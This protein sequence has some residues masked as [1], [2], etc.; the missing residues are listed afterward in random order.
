MAAEDQGIMSLPQGG[1]EQ[2]PAPQISPDD[3]YDAVR[4]GLEDASPQAAT[5]IQ[6][7]LNNMMPMLDQVDDEQLDMLIQAFQYLL[8]NPEEYAENIKSWVDAGVLDPGMLPEEYDPEIISAI[9]MVLMEARRQRQAGNQRAGEGMAE[10]GMAE[11]PMPPMQM[12]RGGIAEA[13][14]MVASKGRGGD[15][16]LAHINPEEA[17]LLRSRGGAGTINPATGLPEYGWNPFKA[18]AKVVSGAVSGIGKAVSGIGRAVSGVVKSVVKTVKSVVKSPVGR[19]LATMALAAFIGPTALGASLGSAGT[20]ALSSGLVTAVGGGNVK[21]ILRSAATA[22]LGAPGGP[23]SEYVSGT[24][25][26]GAMNIT[27]AAAASAINAGIVGTGVGLLSGQKLADAVKSGL[28]SGAIS[29]GMTGLQ[30]GF[31]SQLPGP[32]STTPTPA[33][34]K[35]PELQMPG[36]QAPTGPG[37]APGT[38]TAGPLA[39]IPGG[40][41]AGY[42][43]I[44][45]DIAQAGLPGGTSPAYD[46][47]YGDI[48]QRGAAPGAPGAAPA[49][50]PGAP[51]PVPGVMDSL[52]RIGGGITDVLK[53]DFEK[54]FAG[55]KGGAGDLFLPGSATPAELRNSPEYQTAISKGAT[56][57]AALAEAGKTYNPSIVRSYG[58]GV[59][60]GLGI[61]AMSGGFT[62]KQVQPSALAQQLSSRDSYPS[63][64]QDPSKYYVQGLPGVKYDDRGMIIGS[65]PYAPQS[66]V[67]DVRV[68]TPGIMP[69][70][71]AYTPPAPAYTPPQYALGSPQGVMQPYNTSA[72]YSNLFQ[73]YS[74]PLYRNDGGIASLAG[75]GYPRR[76]GQISG[77]GTE[78]SDSIPA[79]LSDG[80]FVMTAKAVRGA[81]KGDRRAG[82]KK[83]YALMHQLERNASRG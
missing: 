54:G 2:P 49:G 53:G 61:M 30:R 18:V 60:A 71:P 19:I 32:Q 65:T 6:G 11:M 50:V 35:A 69:P 79:M 78:K 37:Q 48:A 9:L 64:E 27:N 62:P 20:A 80:E 29:G 22:Y 3:A 24:I 38:T 59:A 1:A 21:D 68:A 55:L 63:I 58:P 45:G 52:G 74:A 31:G 41:S 66:T 23:V 16:V 83:M 7:L 15:T 56:D 76:T 25:G 47:I 10:E 17:R 13:A 75:G 44:Y 26:A 81:G 67:A 70:A 77:P 28:V 4:G 57:A 34:S 36:A 12:A 43:Q 39:A 42:D 33:T 40:P 46:Q 14:R 8:D 73:P 51:R 5:D 72:M 82:A